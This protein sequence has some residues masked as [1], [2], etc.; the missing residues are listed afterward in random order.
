[1]AFTSFVLADSN[2]DRLIAAVAAGDE[3]T[4]AS[5]YHETSAGVY[6]SPFLF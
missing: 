1:M 2:L 3:D 5:L 6:A 4:L